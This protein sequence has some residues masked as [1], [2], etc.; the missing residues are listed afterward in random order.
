MGSLGSILVTSLAEV[1]VP[2]APVEDHL[3]QHFTY[4]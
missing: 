3:Q 2:R 1:I 4:S